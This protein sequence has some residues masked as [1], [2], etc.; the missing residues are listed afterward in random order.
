MGYW[1]RGSGGDP[2]PHDEFRQALASAGAEF[3]P[4]TNEWEVL[5]YRLE[6]RVGVV[7]RNAKGRISLTGAAGQHF[8]NH[9]SGRGIATS[10]KDAKRARRNSLMDASPQLYTDASAYDATRSGSWAAILVMPDGSEHEAH[11]QLKG[12]TV[13]STQAEAAAI[14]NALHHF[15][16]AKLIAEGSA[17]RIVCDNANVVRYLS[18]SSRVRRRNSAGEAITYVRQLQTKAKL[19]LA[20]EWIKGHQP[21][22]RAASDPRIAYNRR[23]DKL[24]KVHSHALHQERK[25]ATA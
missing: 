10:A 18:T 16:K 12:E 3:L 2:F 13:S 8:A 5:R 1:L 22:H 15:L 19:R 24:A 6:D 20:C 21:L 23:C 14:A 11:G 9:S 4:L 25:G 7:Y 17:V